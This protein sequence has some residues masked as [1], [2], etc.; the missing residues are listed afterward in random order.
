MRFSKHTIKDSP[1]ALVEGTLDPVG[2]LNCR[3]NHS[4]VRQRFACYKDLEM[5]DSMQE[6]QASNDKSQL[7]RSSGIEARV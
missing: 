6:A 5:R 7:D 3:H 2:H 1:Q 4:G